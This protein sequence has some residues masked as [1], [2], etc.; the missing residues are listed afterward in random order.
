MDQEAFRYYEQQWFGAELQGCEKWGHRNDWGYKLLQLL[1]ILFSVLVTS[2]I[3]LEQFI[4]GFP[5]RPSALIASLVVTSAASALK[6][7]NFQE[8]A[9]YYSGKADAL[10]REH[11]LYKA[12]DGDYSGA[13][14]KEQLFVRRIEDIIAESNKQRERMYFPDVVQ[15]SSRNQ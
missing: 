12:A 6:I 13:T 14:D 5:G 1:V 9:P 7:F 3:A 8:K 2:A 15:T 4:P 11:F 10:K